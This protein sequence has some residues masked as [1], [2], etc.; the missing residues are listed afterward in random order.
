[1]KTKTLYTV[2]ALLLI[3]STFGQK[4]TIDLTFTAVDNAAY[5]QLD[6]IKVMNITQHTNATVYWPDTSLSL[7]IS[8][9]DTLLYIG[10]STGSP[11]GI[12]DINYERNNF[13]LFQNYPNPATDHTMF[14]F[15]IPEKGNVQLSV[16]DISGKEVFRSERLLNNGVHSF[17]F[18]LGKGNIFI[19]TARWNGINRSIKI[20]T[21]EANSRNTCNIDYI[22]SKHSKLQL[23]T[24]SVK[25]GVIESGIL[26]TP[27]TNE[28][29]TFQ[30]AYNIPCLGTPSVTYSGQVYNTVQI[31]S[32]CWLKENLNVGTMINGASNMTDNGVIEKYCF[33]NNQVNCNKYGGLYKW[34]EMMQ[35]NP[36]QGS[37]GI[38]PSGW[39]I[40]CD[41]E[42]KI[43]EGAADSQYGIGDPVWNSIA[44]RGFDAGTNLRSKF[45]W[46]SPGNG[47]DILGFT[48]LPGGIINDAGTFFLIGFY[49]YW[50]SSTESDNNNAWDHFLNYN[51]PEVYR[52]NNVKGYSFN[53][54]CVKD[55]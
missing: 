3:V 45:D 30:Y 39:H 54:R 11:I 35:Y 52:L 53:V 36:Q 24:S 31:L 50:W 26:D 8:A 28:T 19:L 29:Y 41:E 20:I 7:D 9:G 44:I 32:Q 47:T 4:V 2:T 13:K 38:C 33:N 23:K 43:L 16:T 34:N 51:S 5:V 46:E 6:S 42:W 10:Y 12:E 14:S 37:Q 22:E 55:E 15:T 1:M 25:K 18:S 48:G 21:T 49:G 17:R 27:I 40:P